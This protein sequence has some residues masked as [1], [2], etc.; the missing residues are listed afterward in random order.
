MKYTSIWTIRH[1]RDGKVIWEDE[2]ANSLVQEGEES[3]LETYFRGDATYIPTEFYV[4]LCNDDLVT[5]TTLSTVSGEPADTYGYEP[6][7]IERSTV[8]F[9]TKEL[10]EG[11]YRIISKLISFTASGGSIGP[12]RTAY[13]AT[14]LDNTGKLLAFRSLTLSRTILDGDTMTLQ[15]RIQLS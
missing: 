5:T 7:L 12:V 8:G 13:L 14:T 6:Q 15:F 4:R 9:Q 3:I 11:V 1:W 2:K 10:N